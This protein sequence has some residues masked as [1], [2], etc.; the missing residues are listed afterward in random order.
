MALRERSIFRLRPDSSTQC[1]W[2][3]YDLRATNDLFKH[4]TF[5]LLDNGSLKAGAFGAFRVPKTYVQ[6]PTIIIP[7]SAIVTTGNAKLQIEYRSVA[8]GESLD[9]ASYQETVAA[10]ETVPGTVNLLKDSVLALTGANLA[11]GDILA[12]YLSLR[13]DDAATTLASYVILHDLLFGWNDA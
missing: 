4:A 6:S 2:E 12:F 13:G 3:P 1:W 8:V 7:W 10:T 11:A 5:V 9:Q